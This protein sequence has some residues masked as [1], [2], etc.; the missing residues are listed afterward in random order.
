ME[1]IN[2][3]IENNDV[4]SLVLVSMMDVDIVHDDKSA[5]RTKCETRIAVLKSPKS[6]TFHCSLKRWCDE[7]KT[8]REY[9]ESLTCTELRCDID[10]VVDRFEL[11][12]LF[13]M[14]PRYS[15]CNNVPYLYSDFKT[16]RNLE[17][18]MSLLDTVDSFRIPSPSQKIKLIFGKSFI[19]QVIIQLMGECK[20]TLES[21]ILQYDEI[22]SFIKDTLTFFKQN[23]T[24]K[25]LNAHNVQAFIERCQSVGSSF[26]NTIFLVLFKCIE[27]HGKAN[28]YF[29][30][31]CM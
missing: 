18:F 31:I 25:S 21:K 7:I 11:F 1:I 28:D 22:E 10:G 13:E 6:K 30:R 3:W 15:D 2:K 4:D 12:T 5:N 8:V 17:R 14:F 29:K 27:K 9:F 16:F 26:V 20:L 24:K 19:D 23:S